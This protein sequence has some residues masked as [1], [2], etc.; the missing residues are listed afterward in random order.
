MD[1][2]IG[3]VLVDYGDLN[4]HFSSLIATR[5]ILASSSSSSFHQRTFIR[6]Y[7][8]LLLMELEHGGR[9]FLPRL[10]RS[11]NKCQIG[12]ALAIRLGFL[13]LAFV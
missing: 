10:W 9:L 4:L 3:T 12:P 6:W 8:H 11:F 13:A 1:D 5:M 2:C 7:Y